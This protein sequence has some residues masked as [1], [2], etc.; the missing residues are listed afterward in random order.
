MQ[1]SIERSLDVLDIKYKNISEILETPVFFDSVEVRQV[2][3]EIQDARNSILYV[4]NSLTDV[5][6]NDQGAIQDG[7]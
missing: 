1:D 3:S 4:A 7:N 2:L 5:N 6:D